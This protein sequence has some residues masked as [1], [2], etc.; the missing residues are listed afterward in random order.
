VED[1]EGDLFGDGHA[2]FIARIV[3]HLALFVEGDRLALLDLVTVEK[4]FLHGG[5]AVRVGRTVLMIERGQRGSANLGNATSFGRLLGASATMRKIHPL[6]Q[7]L[8]ANDRA[9]L[10]EGEV[11]TGK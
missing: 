6:L 7:A 3:R 1:R 4:A 5:E 11:G 8:A 2:G 9:V 10:V